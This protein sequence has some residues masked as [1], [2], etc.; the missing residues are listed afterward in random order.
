M[1]SHYE[2]SFVRR[3]TTT[4][5]FAGAAIGAAMAV[6]RWKS[7]RGARPEPSRPHAEDI[8]DEAAIE[9]FPA[10]DPPSHTPVAGVRS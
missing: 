8:V 2:S 7:H 1:R 5:A 9:S 4:L 6:G 3:L 10:S